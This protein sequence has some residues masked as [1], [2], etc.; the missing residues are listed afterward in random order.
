MRKGI[1]SDETLLYFFYIYKGLIQLN[2]QRMLE[3]IMSDKYFVSTF[4]ALEWDP[5]GLEVPDDQ[6]GAANN[7][8]ADGGDQDQDQDQRNL[9]GCQGGELEDMKDVNVFQAEGTPQ[10]LEKVGSSLAED[11]QK[12][13]E[14]I[15]DAAEEAEK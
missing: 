5:D 8:Q 12:Q 1:N 15:Q 14:N 6:L 13:P 3:I 9:D 11:E 2:D 10:D 4:G 7:D